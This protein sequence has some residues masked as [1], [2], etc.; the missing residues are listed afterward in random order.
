MPRTPGQRAAFNVPAELG[1]VDREILRCIAGEVTC[2]S[3]AWSTRRTGIDA[4]RR[5]AE[6]LSRHLN[7]SREDLLAL[8]AYKRT[9]LA[10]YI[11]AAA[12]APK[13]S[14][15]RLIDGR[16]KPQAARKQARRPAPWCGDQRRLAEDAHGSPLR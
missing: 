6:L 4:Q 7:M 1:A 9:Q 3:L 8:N 16:G 2:E 11:V 5:M 12:G 10:G 14:R 15:A 13:K